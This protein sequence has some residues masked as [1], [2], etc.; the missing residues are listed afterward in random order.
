MPTEVA[1][2]EWSETGLADV[3]RVAEEIDP[4]PAH[5]LQVCATSLAL[6][7]ELVNI[8]GL[9]DQARRVLAAGALL[10]DTGWVTKPSAHHKG[11]RNVVL[12]LELDGFTERERLMVACVA[13]YHRKAHPKSS[14]KVYKDLTDA[15]Q[16]V[17]QKLAALVR[18]ADGLDR[19]HA[20]STTHVR[21][22]RDQETMCI[23]V[24]QRRTDTTAVWGAMR[25]RRLFEETFGVTV[26]VLTDDQPAPA[27]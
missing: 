6:F 15:D 22:T 21:V 25:K 8:H 18:I 23:H 9:D 26:D 4:E 13:R 16:Q 12:E 10:H 17:V 20:A 24:G 1:L 5:A 3:Q 2:P 11:S 7:D 14:H 19:S 27:P